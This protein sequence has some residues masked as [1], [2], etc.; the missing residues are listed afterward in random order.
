ML[1]P[2]VLMIFVFKAAENFSI[3]R[4]LTN[5]ESDCRSLWPWSRLS[6]EWWRAS[7][8]HHLSFQ[9]NLSFINAESECCLFEH[10]RGQFLQG[11]NFGCFA[12]FFFK[13][14][15]C[16]TKPVNLAS[17]FQLILAN[18][19]RGTP[20]TLWFDLGSQFLVPFNTPLLALF[21]NFWGLNKALVWLHLNS[22]NI[23]WWSVCMYVC[24][25][26]AFF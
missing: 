1:S 21:G 20:K 4:L 15:L 6:C 14:S 23:L 7:A 16:V 10:H 2:K 19:I 25:I 13:L 12:S 5:T 9:R 18:C 22:L 24:H 11:G 8:E 3:Q 17:I 26:F